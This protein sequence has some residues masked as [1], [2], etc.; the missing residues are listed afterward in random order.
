MIEYSVNI[1]S[2]HDKVFVMFGHFLFMI[3]AK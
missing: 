2:K 3:N 1:I